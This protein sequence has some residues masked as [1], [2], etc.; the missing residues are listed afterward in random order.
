MAISRAR[1][2]DYAERLLS[3]PR[4]DIPLTLKRGRGGVT[5]LHRGRAVTKCHATQVG[6]LQAGFM[7]EA[8]GIEVPLPGEKATIRVPAGV[9]YRA[10]AISSLDLRR[11]EARIVL[12][13]HLATA[14]MQRTA[15]RSFEA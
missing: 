2:Q 5:L 6:A 8:L 1:A 10:V 7:A 3:R 11:A 9:L 14:H 12:G 13:Q 4:S 15:M